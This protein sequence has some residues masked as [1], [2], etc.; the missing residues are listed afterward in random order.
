MNV[1]LGKRCR[2]RLILAGSGTGFAPIWA[3]ACMALREFRDRP[4]VL[5]AGAPRLPALYMTLALLARMPNVT[6]I[7]TI[8]DGP[9]PHPSVRIGRIEAQMP[10][11]TASD[12]LYACGSPRMVDALADSVN[13]ASATFY[14]DPFE[15]SGPDEPAGLFGML[16]TLA[17][18]RRSAP[19]SGEDPSAERAPTLAPARHNP[20]PAPWQSD[21]DGDE[22]GHALDSPTP[23]RRRQAASASGGNVVSLAN[24]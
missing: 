23:A 17:Q 3:I 1:F 5:I 2:D 24:G 20:Q 6:V 8:E 16:K 18:P 19:H 13:S 9:S 14:A 12:T 4:I 11:L 7:P 15:A 22:P 10:P 21:S